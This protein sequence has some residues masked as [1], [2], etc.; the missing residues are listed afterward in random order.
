M[1]FLMYIM[2]IIINWILPPI[3]DGM[4]AITDVPVFGGLIWFCVAIL[5]LVAMIAVPT[6]YV[7]QGLTDYQ[8]NPN[9]V[10]EIVAALLIF[11][12]GVLLTVKGWYWIPIFDSL[13]DEL[14]IRVL[15]YT[16]II[17]TWTELVVFTPVYLII[18]AYGKG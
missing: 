3:I 17:L 5:W 16:G 11:A 18:R 8:Q 6:M 4:E 13:T 12:F 15:F 2:V 14:F 7:Y 1:F 10:A 9:K